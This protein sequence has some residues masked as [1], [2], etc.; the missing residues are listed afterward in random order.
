MMDKFQRW[1]IGIIALDDLFQALRNR[2]IFRD[3]LK[4]AAQ[5]LGFILG[6]PPAWR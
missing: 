4:V 5:V 3:L 2:R 1:V 6:S